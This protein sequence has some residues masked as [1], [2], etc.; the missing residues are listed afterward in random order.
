MKLDSNI[1][2]QR[3]LYVPE[4]KFN[5]LSVSKLLAIQRLCI[6]IYPSECI[7]QDLTTKEVVATAPEHGG[8]YFLQPLPRCSVK[9][10]NFQAGTVQYKD[11]NKKDATQGCFTAANKACSQVH[12]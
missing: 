8:L 11:G 6:H 7:F 9:K 1:L 10:D 5:L 12:F 3:V 2:L 4:F